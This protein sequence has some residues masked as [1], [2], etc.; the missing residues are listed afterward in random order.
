VKRFLV[1]IALLLSLGVNVGVLTT[2]AVSRYRDAG[3]GG[4]ASEAPPSTRSGEPQE[5]GRLVSR[6]GLEGSERQ[7]FLQVQREFFDSTREARAR[8]EILRSDLRREVAADVPDR[9][10]IEALL[11]KMG[12]HAVALDRALV[13]NILQSRELLDPEQERVFLRFVAE[14]LRPRRQGAMG[15]GQRPGGRDA[16]RDEAEADAWR[17]LPPRPRP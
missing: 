4:R 8:L 14:R 11:Q 1:P 7:R 9:P 6:L 16:N 17:D 2:L 5:V 10:A 15:G 3:D 13:A 12:E